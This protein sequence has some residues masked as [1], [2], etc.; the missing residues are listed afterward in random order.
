MKKLESIRILFLL[1][2][3]L[4]LFTPFSLQARVNG[5]IKF[6]DYYRYHI[7]DQSQWAQPDFNDSLWQKAK[8]GSFP[9]KQWQGIGWLRYKLEVD[10]SLLNKPMGFTLEL[11]GAVEIYLDGQLIC[12]RGK[13]GTSAAN[14]ESYIEHE[15]FLHTILFP[16]PPDTSD[17]KSYHTLAVRYSSF[18]LELPAWSGGTPYFRFNIDD[19]ETLNSVAARKI[20]VKTIHQMFLV[21]VYL[22]LALLHLLLFLFYPKPRANFYYALLTASSAMSIF[23]LFQAFQTN[24]PGSVLLSLQLFSVG[25]ILLCLSGLR[26]LYS[27][28]YTRPPKT[29]ILFLFVGFVLFIWN[30]FQPYRVQNAA[31]LLSLATVPECIRAIVIRSKG[32]IKRPMKGTWIIGIGA[33]PLILTG[34]YQILIELHIIEELWL[35]DG[36][37]R[38]YYAMLALMIAMS[39]FL[40]R[41]FAMTN[42]NLEAKLVQVQE[43]SEEA[44]EQQRACMQLEA[45]NA[46]KNQELEEARKLQLSMLPKSVP[47]L[48]LYQIGVYMQTAT[49]VGG[50]YYD[51]FIGEDGMLTV[52]IGDAT[53]HGLQAGTMVTAAK[54][55]FN[56]F[57]PEPKP[58]TFLKKTSMALRKMGFRKMFMAMTLAK[59]KGYH[60]EIAAAGMPFTLIFHPADNSVEEVVLKGIPLGSFE[61]FPYK[62]AAIDLGKGDTVLFMSD[63]LP[64]TFNLQDEMLGFERVKDL[65]MEV[66]AETPANVIA[67]L[68]KAGKEWAEGRES[69]DD[70]TLMVIKIK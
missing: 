2:T 23:F 45:E 62:E 44:L 64:E 7:G 32:K 66:G 35:S 16:P 9:V 36:F 26:F 48:P 55:L 52:V 29:F 67:H 28:L 31:T 50:D 59:F 70:V 30:F 33:I 13:I 19:L 51:F 68:V 41:R 47:V 60:L 5:K 40:A 39:I 10:A 53:G 1:L 34:I 58:V 3:G 61:N 54:S 37:P 12:Q 46:R 11:Q 24:N 6:P 42:K 57:A 49:E 8:W 65:F 18:F 22:A 27:L 43:L 20:K 25:L 14:E 56:A 69:H 38:P 63:G 17:K 21:G 15:T 4:I